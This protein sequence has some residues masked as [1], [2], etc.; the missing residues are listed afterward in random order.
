MLGLLVTLAASAVGA[1]PFDPDDDDPNAWFRFEYLNL[2]TS[3]PSA[4]APLVTTGDAKS[5]GR[6]GFAQTRPLF[7]PGNLPSTVLPGVKLTIGGWLYDDLLG[8]EMS[9]FTTT[10]RASH[11]SASSDASGSPL[12]AVPFADVTSGTPQESSLVVSQPGVAR[13]R[14]WADDAVVLVGA[15]LDGLASLNEYVYN[16]DMSLMLL[17]GLKMLAFRERF[18]FSSGTDFLS[19]PSVSHNDIFLTDDGFFGL[20]LGVRGIRRFG[21]WTIQATGRTAIGVTSTLS[22]VAA[23]DSLSFYMTRI[24]TVPGEGFF[25]EPSNIGWRYSQSFSVVPAGQLRIGYALSKR[26]RLT[27]GYEAFYWTR[28]LRAPNQIDREINLNQFAGAAR[29]APTPSFSNFWAQGFTVGAQI[30]Y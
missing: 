18:K 3:G 5:L 19:G 17:G 14:A 27:L 13:G 15:D 4:G 9:L 12:L 25:A 28:M 8:A 7:A 29:P 10:L 2:W 16:P 21:R 23:Q 20:D 24:R 26:V 22:Y 30:N 1:A 11:F 6:L